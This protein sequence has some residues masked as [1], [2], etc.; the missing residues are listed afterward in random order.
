M[1]MIKRI[2]GWKW[3]LCAILLGSQLLLLGKLATSGSPNCDET[4]HIAGGLMIWEYGDYSLYCVNPPL[5]RALSAIPVFLMGT[6]DGWANLNYDIESRPEFPCGDELVASH[7]DRWKAFLICGRLMLMPFSL[8]G[9]VLCF[10]WAGRLYGTASAFIALTLWC[11]CP[12]TLTWNSVICSDGL[13]T[14]FGLAAAYSFWRWL[15]QP[16]WSKALVAGGML[17]LAQLSK[18]TWIIQFPLWIILWTVCHSCYGSHVSRKMQLTQLLTILLLG[19]YILNLGYVFD[20]SFTQLKDYHFVS[21]TL[22]SE[23]ADANVRVNGG[24]RFAHSWLGNI[25]FPLPEF[26]IRGVDLQKADFEKAKPSY[27]FGKWSDH[28][29]WYYYLVGLVLKTPLATLALALVALVSSVVSTR[30]THKD[31]RSS[32]GGNESNKREILADQM[33]LVTPAMALFVFVSLQDGFSRHFRY[34]LPA[35]PFAYIWISRVGRFVTIKHAW[36]S[37]GIISLLLWSICSSLT[38]YPHSMSYFNELAGGPKNGH[39]YML[40]SSFSWSQDVFYLKTW[41]DDHLKGEVPFVSVN[42]NI[43]EKDFGI[44]SRGPS[45]PLLKE[46]SS[47][48]GALVGPVPGWHAVDIQWLCDPRMG[49]AYFSDFQPVACVGTSIY[50]YHISVNDAK[51]VRQKLGLDTF[52]FFNVRSDQFVRRLAQAARG[53]GRVTIAIYSDR[54]VTEAAETNDPLLNWIKSQPEICYKLLD[55]PSIIDGQL[56]GFDLV[57]FPGGNARMQ[58]DSL[59]PI[60]RKKVQE[61]VR[62]GGS[63]LGI[64]AGAFLASS[65]FE[66][67]LSLVNSETPTGTCYVKGLGYQKWLDRGGGDA[68]ITISSEGRKIFGES[69]D[70]SY[71]VRFGGGPVF[72][73]GRR[74]Y[75]PEYVPLAYY[76]SEVY[77]F[78]F[79]KGTMYGTPAILATPYGS[80]KVIL[81]SPHLESKPELG[82]ALKKSIQALGRSKSDSAT[83]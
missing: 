73:P 8:L 79:Q 51:R 80:G 18:M 25:P 78:D 64:C 13:A 12:N 68:G 37:V 47:G 4:A 16:R 24:N 76:T 49:Y 69:T 77:Q 67:G 55:S 3:L 32:P 81:I 50:V 46:S 20:G 29:W 23:E 28:G 43:S 15:R 70:T 48:S 57:L 65:T 63:Y 34:V 22:G 38:V 52:E 33:V 2:R 9:G 61:F 6:S 40:S 58:A 56:S 1:L 27:L 62:N 59:G 75:L 21:R 5:T 35:L 54:P 66:W 41:L 11:F 53:Q 30:P 72:Q 60:G 42:T 31:S 39:K 71:Q 44:A 83:E 26:Y 7:P 82:F 36:V 10:Q 45:P 19:A 17:G 74:T 14:C